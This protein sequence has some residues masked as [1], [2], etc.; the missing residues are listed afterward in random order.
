MRHLVVLVLWA[1]KQLQPTPRAQRQSPTARFSRPRHRWASEPR[2]ERRRRPPRG[3]QPAPRH[4]LAVW[5]KRR[6][7]PA[8]AAPLA[9]PRPLQPLQPLQV[10]LPPSE[11][12]QR[13]PRVPRREKL[14][15]RVVGV[16][17]HLP[18]D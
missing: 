4:V 17:G 16:A 18:R 12:Q 7:G 15:R 3:R 14:L 8:L 5:A 2:Q 6:L 10:F 13:I 1:T 9:A 11:S